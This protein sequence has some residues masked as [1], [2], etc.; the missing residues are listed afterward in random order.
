ML[1]N[2][3]KFYTVAMSRYEFEFGQFRTDVNFYSLE[4]VIPAEGS[5]FIADENTKYLIPEEYLDK[6]VILPPG[7]ENKNWD[8]IDTILSKA[9]ELELGR[10]A[11]FVGVGGG[12]ICDMTAFASS[13]YMRGCSVTLVPTTVLAMVDASLGG[14]S[15]IDYKN[16]KNLVGAFYPATELRIAI[17][18]LKTLP[19]RE[20]FSGL[21]EVIKSAMLG[22]EEL[23]DTLL[24]KS[25]EILKK[26]K[27]TLEYII[28]HCIQI[29]GSIVE[30]DLYEKS[31]RA[32]LNLGHT[33]GHALETVTGFSSFSHGEGVAW[34]IYK[35]VETAEALGVIDPSYAEKS[36][37]MIELYGYRTEAQVDI[38]EFISAMKKDKKKKGGI[39]KFILQRNICDTFIT[40]V[41]EALIRKICS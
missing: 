39:V 9:T 15:G 35:A 5:L 24:T 16:Y 40:E 18:S 11:L 13:L 31:I 2:E 33:F 14:K 34:G 25:E 17:D 38:D 22:D 23:F 3:K 32:H 6:T 26:E 1:L 20:F 19:E 10:D 7:E 21:A 37:Q 12:V 8:S 27:E 41:D 30:Q 36:R 28:D 29:K 4:E